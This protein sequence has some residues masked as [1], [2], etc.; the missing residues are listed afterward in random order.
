MSEKEIEEDEEQEESLE[1]DES[2]LEEA[3]DEEDI[4]INSQDLDTF[5]ADVEIPESSPSLEKINDPQRGFVRL[6]S[7]VEE[8]SFSGDSTKE[9]DDPFN[10]NSSGIKSEDPK[11]TQR[12]DSIMGEMMLNSEIENIG[13]ED[14]FERKEIGFQSSSQANVSPVENFKKYSPMSKTEKANMD[15]ADSFERKE[16]KY[17]SDKR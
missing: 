9:A 13:K 17:F 5:L 3:L 16:I 11:Y 1:D 12:N 10:Y 6:E 2:S 7:G 8:G 14:S 4:I 15:K